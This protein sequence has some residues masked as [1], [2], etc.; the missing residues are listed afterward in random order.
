MASF[1]ALCLH[2]IPSL[3]GSCLALLSAPESSCVLPGIKIWWWKCSSSPL[4]ATAGRVRDHVPHS[5]LPLSFLTW[6]WLPPAIWRTT[7]KSCL[8]CKITPRPLAPGVWHPHQRTLF[9]LTHVWS[10]GVCALQSSSVCCYLSLFSGFVDHRMWTV[11]SWVNV[12]K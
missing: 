1:G 11:H 9:R 3:C 2:F 5:L 7:A 12:S 6:L 8:L 10:P 4:E